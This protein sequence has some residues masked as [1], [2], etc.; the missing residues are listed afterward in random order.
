MPT[1]AA[2]FF[3]YYVYE[4]YLIQNCIKRHLT[5]PDRLCDW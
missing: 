1:R 2:P 4:Q 5:L 3:V